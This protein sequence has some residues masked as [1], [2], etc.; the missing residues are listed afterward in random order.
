[1]CAD[2]VFVVCDF[3]GVGSCLFVLLGVWVCV[4][5]VLWMTEM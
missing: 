4:V 3:G 1:V 5:R 2:V